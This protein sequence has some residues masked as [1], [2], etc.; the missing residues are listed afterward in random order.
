MLRLALLVASIRR[1]LPADV[2]WAELRYSVAGWNEDGV[3]VVGDFRWA[4]GTLRRQFP[5]LPVLLVG[6]S[7]GGRVATCGSDEE[8]LCGVLGL[9]PW[10]PAE[11]SVQPLAGSEFRIVHGE[12]DREVPVASTE[13]FLSAAR[14]AGVVVIRTLVPGG[15]HSMLRR[16]RTWNAVVV[17]EI[18]FS[19]ARL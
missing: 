7:M 11:D 3:S 8:G 4:M 2:I 10:L 6:H 15:E 19:L 12:N 13:F 16:I 5:H 9:A 1:R 18:Q 17:R 14:A